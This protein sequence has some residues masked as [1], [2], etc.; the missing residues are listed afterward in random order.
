[1]P[2]TKHIGHS[3]NMYFRTITIIAAYRGRIKL[4]TVRGR[5]T[6]SFMLFKS[7]SSKCFFIALEQIINMYEWIVKKNSMQWFKEEMIR[8]VRFE[9]YT[10]SSYHCAL[11]PWN[12]AIRQRTEFEDLHIS[13][14]LWKEPVF[15]EMTR[16]ECTWKIYLAQVSFTWSCSNVKPT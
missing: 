14:N 11:R 10:A 9:V 4:L 7:N 8:F 5:Y 1:M 15:S 16:S 6:R 12:I 2:L 3:H 13:E